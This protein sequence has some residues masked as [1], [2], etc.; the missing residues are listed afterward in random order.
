MKRDRKKD[1]HVRRF[2]EGEYYFKKTAY[3]EDL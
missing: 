3:I 2:N 1:D